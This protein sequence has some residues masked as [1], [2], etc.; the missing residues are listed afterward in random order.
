MLKYKCEWYGKNLKYIGRFEPSSKTC[1]DCGLINTELK[2]QHREWT[3]E[4]G[5]THDRDFNAAINIKN[6]GLRTQPSGVNV[7]HKPKRSLRVKA[8]Q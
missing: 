2:L 5:V 1:S 7:R 8:T 6:L 4:C 3:C